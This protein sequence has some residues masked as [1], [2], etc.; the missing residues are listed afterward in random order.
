[1][2]GARTRPKERPQINPRARFLADVENLAEAATET[3]E[4]LHASGLGHMAYKLERAL[5]QLGG[6]R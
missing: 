1:M 5:V 4:N 6:Q 2:F 3:A